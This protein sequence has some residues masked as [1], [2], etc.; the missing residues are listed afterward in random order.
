MRAISLLVIVSP[1]LALDN[2]LARTPPLGFNPWNCFGISAKG[3]C[4][5]PLPWV[6]SGPKCH[7]FNETVILDIANAVASSP[8]KAAGYEFINLDCGYS[9]KRRDKHGNLVVNTTRYPHGLVWLG[10]QLHGLGLKFGMYSD[11]GK[12]QCC[13]RIDPHS[14]DGSAGLEARDAALFASFGVDCLKHDSCGEQPASYAAM[15]DALNAT[16]RKV[17][18]SARRH[19]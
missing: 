1:A 16:G 11:A 6:E 5:L 15:R 7:G 4:K 13:S 14:D 2:G 10:E 12:Q 19:F 9:T 17:V 8:L 18:Y 3:T